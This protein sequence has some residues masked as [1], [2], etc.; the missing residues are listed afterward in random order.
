MYCWV[1]M[2]AFGSTGCTS[3]VAHMVKHYIGRTPE[4]LYITNYRESLNASL[5]MYITVVVANM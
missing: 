5:S 4:G 3:R 2:V 1:F